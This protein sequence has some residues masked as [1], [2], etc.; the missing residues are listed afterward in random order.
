[1]QPAGKTRT[2]LVAALIED[3]G[4]GAVDVRLALRRPELVRTLAL[5]EPL[6]STLLRDAGDPLS[7]ECRHTAES[8]VHRARAGQGAQ[9]WALFLDHR[10][11]PGTR[12]GM[13][14][15][16]RAR[17]LA[18]TAEGFLSNPS[19]PMAPGDCR[20]VPAQTTIVR[21]GETTAPDRRV[22]ELLRD[23][24]PGAGR[25]SSPT[26]PEELARI[27]IGHLER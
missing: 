7:D 5:V 1:M 6:L 12:A 13:A 25:M 19:N 27:V 24:I 2:D 15:K 18:Q 21:G 8:F 26:R 3:D 23:A 14:D 11:G 22:A 16:A 10:N 17:F 20:R 9:A 4:S